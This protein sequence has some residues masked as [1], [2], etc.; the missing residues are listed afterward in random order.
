M[1]ADPGYGSMCRHGLDI[2]RE[3]HF[4]K[5]PSADGTHCATRKLRHTA[6]RQ[7]LSTVIKK[8]DLL[9]AVATNAT[10]GIG[11]SHTSTPLLSWYLGNCLYDYFSGSTLSHSESEGIDLPNKTVEK[12][13]R[14][15]SEIQILDHCDDPLV[16]I[17]PCAHGGRLETIGL[18]ITQYHFA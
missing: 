18:G 2:R 3:R 13:L 11:T 12:G 16:P 1:C 5:I 4:Q 17:G 9:T 6:M 10:I 14:P 7:L 8:I 15:S